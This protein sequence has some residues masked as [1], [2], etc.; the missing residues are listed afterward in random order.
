MNSDL[1]GRVL[2]AQKYP[3]RAAGVAFIAERGAGGGGEAEEEVEEAATGPRIDPLRRNFETR[4]EGKDLRG[5]FRSFRWPIASLSLSL[6]PHISYVIYRHAV[7]S[8]DL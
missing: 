3:L 2:P 1:T 5:E 6:F 7:K 4:I 8:P